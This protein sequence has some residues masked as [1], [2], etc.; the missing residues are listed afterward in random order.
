[1][2]MDSDSGTTASPVAMNPNQPF[3]AVGVPTLNISSAT[4][5]IAA[6][7]ITASATPLDLSQVDST[8]IRRIV[9][10]N[11]NRGTL[12]LTITNPL[13]IGAA[14][15][16]TFRSPTGS[17]PAITPITKNVTIAP[18]T[19]GTT[20]TTTTAAVNLTGAELRRMFGRDIEA[21]FGGTT[22]AGTA[23]VTPTQKIAISSRIQVNFTLKEQQP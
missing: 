6:Q 23:T 22:Q 21:V 15:T 19:S 3:T 4:V 2:T 9:D 7:P 11:Q 12:Y 16:I 1:M 8:I 17:S 18:A 5:A 10:D 13:T 14:S 20:P